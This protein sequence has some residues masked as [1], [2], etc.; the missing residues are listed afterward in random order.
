[1]STMNRQEFKIRAADGTELCVGAHPVDGEGPVALVL[2][3]LLT[4]GIPG[5]VASWGIL[6][7]DAI[8][9]AEEV[10]RRHPG[11]PIHG[12]GLSLGA[13]VILA[14]ALKHPAAFE[15]ITLFSPGLAAAAKLPILRRLRLLRRSF[16]DP[17][18][19]YDLPFTVEQLTHDPTWQRQLRADPL[20][21]QQATARFLVELFKMQRA[22]AAGIRD[23]RIP[24]YA[25]LPE[26]DEVVSTARALAILSKAGSPIV[27]IEVFPGA[28][29]ILPS[30][31]PREEILLRLVPWIL[32]N[33]RREAERVTIRKAAPREGEAVRPEPPSLDSILR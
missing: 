16:T 10:S 15:R 20:R 6:V 28:S 3:G 12:V 23:L 30:T 25:L 27:R 13:V 2:H 11:R 7:E 17:L 4:G 29:H 1:M 14:A 32:G 9:V 19:L 26:D 8:R 18:K 33:E 31:L 21:S 24:L 22:V 5:H